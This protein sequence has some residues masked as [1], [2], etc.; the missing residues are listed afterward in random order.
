MSNSPAPGPVTPAVKPQ[1]SPLRCLSGALLAG[2]LGLLLYRLTQAIALSF[3]THPLHSENQLVQSI[4]VAVRTLV[5][6]LA[7]MGTGIFSLSALG[8]IAL[9]VQLLLQRWRQR[10][11]LP[12]NP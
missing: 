7:T 3:A 9:A 1:T 4:T 2:S 10:R 8:L 5:V 11:T 6:G 12:P